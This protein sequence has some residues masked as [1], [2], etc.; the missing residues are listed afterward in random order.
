[1]KRLTRGSDRHFS[2]V[3]P[4]SVTIELCNIKIDAEGKCAVELSTVQPA[5]GI[6]TR[7]VLSLYNSESKS[8][9][10][11][12]YV[13][14]LIKQKLATVGGIATFHTHGEI[15][16]QYYEAA[17]R[18]LHVVHFVIVKF[19]LCFVKIRQAKITILA[20]LGLD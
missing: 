2:H 11:K 18:F 14:S 15:G 19:M 16:C 9:N 3:C 13:N 12:I 6:A 7:H 20:W 17:S 5:G 1:M 10:N 4:H 8:N